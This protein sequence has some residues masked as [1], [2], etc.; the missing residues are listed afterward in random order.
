MTPWELAL[1]GVLYLSVAYRYLQ[2][3]DPGMA[4]AFLAYAI[5]NVGFI[6]SALAH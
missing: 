3:N 1:A 4:L 2:H 6:W 5:A